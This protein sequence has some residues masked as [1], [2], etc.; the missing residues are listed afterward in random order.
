M[1]QELNEDVSHVDAEA[2]R[3]RITN[4]GFERFAATNHKGLPLVAMIRPH[5][6]SAE[7]YS[8]MRQFLASIFNSCGIYRKGDD[9]FSSKQWD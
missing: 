4:L 1:K 9:A 5:Q 8:R 7:N 3:K 6:A 2:Y